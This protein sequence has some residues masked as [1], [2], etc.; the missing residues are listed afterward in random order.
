M[1]SNSC[2]GVTLWWVSECERGRLII[3]WSVLNLMFLVV[4]FLTCK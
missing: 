1:I 4:I 2:M 3:S